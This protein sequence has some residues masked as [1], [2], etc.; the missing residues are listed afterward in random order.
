[1]LASDL[2]VTVLVDNLY[3]GGYVSCCWLKGLVHGSIAIHQPLSHFDSLTDPVS[4]SV[5]G[6]DDLASQVAALV[7]GEKPAVFYRV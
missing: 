1:M 4:V 2:S 3:I 7:L 6:L 5:V